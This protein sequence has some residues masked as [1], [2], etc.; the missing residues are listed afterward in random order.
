MAKPL[1]QHNPTE[2]LGDHRVKLKPRSGRY[3]RLKERS[4]LSGIPDLARARR[5]ETERTSADLVHV[6]PVDWRAH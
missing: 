3:I 6:P 5:A 4:V 2:V 1:I